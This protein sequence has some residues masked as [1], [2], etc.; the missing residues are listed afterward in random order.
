MASGVLILAE[1]ANGAV[2]PV[3][4]EL[5]GA[6]PVI[7]NHDSAPEQP[8]PEHGRGTEQEEAQ[9]RIAEQVQ[10]P[11]GVSL[12]ALWHSFGAALADLCGTTAS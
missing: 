2:A 1:I 5:V 8:R 9:E 3:T 12:T 7:V 6:A 10:H 4:A 11:R